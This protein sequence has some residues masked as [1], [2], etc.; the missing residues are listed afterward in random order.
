[1]ASICAF[2]TAGGESGQWIT[3]SVDCPAC[4]PST[5][6]TRT[7]TCEKNGSEVSESECS[8]DKPS[9]SYTC[10]EEDPCPGWA[11]DLDG[12]V[13]H[14]DYDCD[15]D[16][17][18]LHGDSSWDSD[19]TGEQCSEKCDAASSC[20][21][22]VWRS[23]DN[24]KCKFYADVITT[25]EDS[26]RFCAIKEGS[27]SNPDPVEACKYILNADNCGPQYSEAYCSTKELPYCN[28]D[29]GW[30][31]DTQAHK[32]A[33][34]DDY[35]FMELPLSCR[36]SMVPEITG[37]SVHEDMDCDGDGTYLNDDSTWD[38]GVTP[39]TCATKCTDAGDSCTGYIW[40]DY[41]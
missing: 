38:E 4:G 3:G 36:E 11:P 14:E 25:S 16:G 10:P 27:D 19:M 41:R 20:S 28:P 33:G 1:M 32:E 9:T 40:R 6:V 13:V 12:Y 35:E 31:G 21:G 37:Y 2:K 7:V 34:G 22:F 29:N 26:G 17:D 18:Y 8:G 24:G 15:S 23:A 30:C 5:T 39:E